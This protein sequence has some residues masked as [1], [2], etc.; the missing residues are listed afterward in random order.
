MNVPNAETGEGGR[1][2]GE[3]IYVVDDEPM[4]LELA[5][6]ILKPLGYTVETFS[7]PV[8]ALHGYE[9]AESKPDLLITDY[10]MPK[11]NGLELAAACRRIRPKQKILLMSGTVGEEVSHGAAVQP[12]CFLPKPYQANQLSDAAAAILAG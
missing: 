8:A 1:N 7:S 6:A 9:A 4:V 10:A 11:M 12:D 3:L 5:S 2:R